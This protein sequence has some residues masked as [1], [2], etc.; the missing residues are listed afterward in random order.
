MLATFS[1]S[2]IPRT[3]ICFL[4]S[5]SEFSEVISILEGIKW[6]LLCS[7]SL[8]S[9]SPCSDWWRKS[10]G[11]GSPWYL[12][13]VSCEPWSDWHS[14]DVLGPPGLRTCLEIQL[15]TCSSWHCQWDSHQ[16]HSDITQRTPSWAVQLSSY[17]YMTLEQLSWI[18]I[19]ITVP[20]S[21]LRHIIY[22]NIEVQTSEKIIW[23]RK[24]AK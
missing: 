15:T 24:F 4:R 22:S 7:L 21:V 23:T 6:A 13:S 18:V 11:K 3:E 10:K 17:F 19:P 16:R 8:T 12:V 2:A 5:L 1:T 9:V 20:P 14:V